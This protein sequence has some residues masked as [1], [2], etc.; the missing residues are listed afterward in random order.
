MNKNSFFIKTALLSLLALECFS[1][2]A[3]PAWT[4]RYGGSGG[5]YAYALAKGLDGCL[6]TGGFTCSPGGRGQY[7]NQIIKTDTAGQIL[8]QKSVGGESNDLLTRLKIMPDGG[9]LALGASDSSPGTGDFQS[10]NQGD[11]DVKIVKLSAGGQFLADYSIGGPGPDWPGDVLVTADHHWLLA[12]SSRNAPDSIGGFDGRL[13]KTDT[14][15]NVLW[16]KTYGG[17]ADD[18]FNNI[19]ATADGGYLLI[20]KSFSQPSFGNGDIWAVKVNAAGEALWQ[21][22]FGGSEEEWISGVLPLNDGCFLGA[23]YSKSGISGNKTTPGNDTRNFWLFKLDANGAKIWE[24]TCL[25]PG[26]QE[27]NDIQPTC[28]GYLLGGTD[29]S[30]NGNGDFIVK[31]VNEL[32][33]TLWT[34]TAGG[35]GEDIGTA[36]LAFEDHFKVLGFTDSKTGEFGSTLGL[37]DNVLIRRPYPPGA[38]CVRIYDIPLDEGWN[39]I[40]SYVNP[41]DPDI[42]QVFKPIKDLTIIVKN[43]DGDVAIPLDSINQIEDWNVREGF[44]VKVKTD[45]ILPIVGTRVPSNM[46]IP[47]GAGWQIIAY[48]RESPMAAPNALAGIANTLIVAK[49]NAGKVFVPAFNIN[50]IGNMAGGQGYDVKLSMADTLTYPASFTGPPGSE[51]VQAKTPPAAQHFMLP[52]TNT[53]NN[54]TLVV[55]AM[56]VGGLLENGDEIGVFTT[57]GGLCGA[58]VFEGQNLA[59]TIWGDDTATPDVTEYMAAGQSFVLRCWKAALNAEIAPDFGLDSG[60]AV[61]QPNGFYV[62]SFITGASELP[63]LTKFNY[64]PNP[65]ASSLH[66]RFGLAKAARLRIEMFSADGKALATLLDQRFTAGPYA[67]DFGLADYAAGL[68]FLR[69]Q[70]DSGSRVFPLVLKKK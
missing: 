64:F 68:H 59:I 21:A 69:A 2:P 39:L 38:E 22:R 60:A 44:R 24:K 16:S 11:W 7:D 10:P 52:P 18:F 58:A 8:W 20:G 41:T 26:D 35:H 30:G 32:G 25:A 23:G 56:A 3:Q 6:Y 43:G 62:L 55:P 63:A 34:A 70:T 50:D 17:T 29:H 36:L 33:D 37:V 61:Y 1:L 14:L 19:I 47:L 67:F 9:L 66:L 48:L 49:N 5:D 54:A 12:C 45:T 27:L 13:V 53:G 65:A 57:G 28:G 42:L 51:L 4:S 46:P 40:S 31:K 15:G